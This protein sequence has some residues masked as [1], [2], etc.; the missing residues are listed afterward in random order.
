MTTDYDVI[1]AML[2]LGGNF[3]QHLARAYRAADAENQHRL[4]AAFADEW[5]RYADL[6][7]RLK[8]PAL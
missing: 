3:I 7:E 2:L 4:K 8:D 6:A 1:D 5:R